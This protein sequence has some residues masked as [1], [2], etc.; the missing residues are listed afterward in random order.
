MNSLAQL[1]LDYGKAYHA[2]QQKLDP[3][4]RLPTLSNSYLIFPLGVSGAHF[5]A[6][7]LVKAN[8]ILHPRIAA[9]I[10]MESAIYASK[11]RGNDAAPMRP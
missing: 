5:A 4:L 3:R 2:F 7:L 6:G 10:A 11:I 9:T 1:H 8:E